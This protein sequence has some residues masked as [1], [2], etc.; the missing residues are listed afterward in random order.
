MSN[1]QLKVSESLPITVMIDTPRQQSLKGIRGKY[2]RL[3]TVIDK[4][5]K[6]AV[7]DVESPERLSLTK[8]S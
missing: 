1:E 8:D 5:T 7:R 2:Q 3:W 4:H 6:A